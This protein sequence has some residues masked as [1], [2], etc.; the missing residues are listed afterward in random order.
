MRRPIEKVQSWMEQNGYD[1]LILSRRDNY[2]WIT[3]GGKN[4]VLTIDQI[5]VASYLI[6]KDNIYLLADSSDLERVFNEENSL[7]GKPILIPW[8]ESKDKFLKQYLM[9]KK[10][11]S[12]TGVWNT[13]NVQEQL[14]DMRMELSSIE[15][16][17]YKIVG[18]ECAQIVESVCKE[19]K[20]SDTEES[21]ACKVKCK[22]MEMGIS[23]DC[24]LVGSDERILDYR[25]P[26]PTKKRIEKSLMVVLG[27]E[28]YGLN[29]SITRM[30]YF[31][32]IPEE[33]KT[34]YTKVQSIFATMQLMMK[35]GMTYDTYFEKV[36][37]LYGKEGYPDEWKMHHQGGPTGYA[38]R[39]FV[40]LPHS[41]KI[42]KNNQAYAWNPTIKGTKCEET[43]YLFEGG[44]ETFTRTK[45]WPSRMIKTEL[46]EF[47]VAD[48]LVNKQ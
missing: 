47:E 14:I 9:G 2:T 26:M 28:K 1:I 32:E 42:I 11:A 40:V 15:I 48:I 23:S 36:K 10:A 37:S 41:S 44:I 34:R 24:V 22:C 27:G 29:V 25:H 46:G 21:I 31:C 12:D 13:S 17:K 38:C 30:V 18:Q 6:E 39:E 20:P 45:E 3:Q 8:Y 19:A 4:H 35:D 33:I 43:T 5:G 7:E 16:D